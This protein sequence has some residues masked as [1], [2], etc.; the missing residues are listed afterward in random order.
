M[1][2]ILGQQMLIF[3]L[4]AVALAA[5][6]LINR[7]LKPVVDRWGL[8][9]WVFPPLFALA[10]ILLAGPPNLPPL[11]TVGALV[12]LAPLAVVQNI[13]DGPRRVAAML[14]VLLNAGL[15]YVFQPLVADAPLGIGIQW[16]A[17]NGA[18]LG[19]CWAGKAAVS[20]LAAMFWAAAIV[21][22]G[23]AIFTTGSF[24]LGQITLLASIP[25]VLAVLHNMWRGATLDP[26]RYATFGLVI[27]LLTVAEHLNYSF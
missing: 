19:L 21:G 12:F 11:Q 14:F 20:R 17:F 25:L 15:Y 7:R 27:P 10:I 24:V 4:P 5:L 1:T 23:I 9:L 2:A 3:G 22:G 13:I 16:L 26:R 6:L 8:D 18:L